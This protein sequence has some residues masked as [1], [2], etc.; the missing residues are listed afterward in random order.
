M[1]ERV[2]GGKE[3]ERR[4]ERENATLSIGKGYPTRDKRNS[5]PVTAKCLIPSLTKGTD[6]FPGVTEKSDSTGRNE[7]VGQ[8]VPEGRTYLLFSSL[9]AFSLTGTLQG[10]EL[11]VSYS[12]P[13]VEA[14]STIHSSATPRF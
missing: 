2:Q 14:Q 11:R 8:P 12:S 10:R 7:P 9:A 4:K 1:F 13:G 6:I 3:R 5:K